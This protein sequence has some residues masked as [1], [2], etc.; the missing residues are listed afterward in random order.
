[1]R[2]LTRTDVQNLIAIPEV[3]DLMRDVFCEVGPGAVNMPQ[4]AVLRLHDGLDSALFMPGHVTNGD[5]VGI[6]IVSV[7]PGNQTRNIIAGKGD[8]VA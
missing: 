3:I 2:V 6:K 8:Y 1:M 7:F 5:R 4:R